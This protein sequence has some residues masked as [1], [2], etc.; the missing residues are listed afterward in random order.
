LDWVSAFDREGRTTWIVDAHSYGKRFIV[1]A[2][3][4]LT[5]FVGLESATSS[6]VEFVEKIVESHIRK[7]YR[8]SPDRPTS[9]RPAAEICSKLGV[10]KKVLNPG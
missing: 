2:E 1:P 9:Y 3:E 5:A 10:I 6:C 7:R 8:I 4:L